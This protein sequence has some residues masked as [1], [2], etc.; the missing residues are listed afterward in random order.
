MVVNASEVLSS[1]CLPFKPC[2]C[3]ES[4][5]PSRSKPKVRR[6]KP[7]TNLMRRGGVFKEIL[8]QVWKGLGW[9]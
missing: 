9:D 3:H 1:V 8:I 5:V 4:G 6:A 2:F 7:I